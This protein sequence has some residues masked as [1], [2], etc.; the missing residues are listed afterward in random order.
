MTLPKFLTLGLLCAVIVSAVAFSWAPDL[1]VAELT[2]RWAPPPSTFVEVK[3]LKVHVRDEGPRN[4]PTP[5]VLLHGTSASLHT[6]DGWVAALKQNRRVIRMDLPG[7]GLTGPNA[8]NDYRS[9]AYARFVLDLMDVLGVQ[10]FVL[11]GNSLGGGIAWHTALLAPHRVERLILVDA[12]GYAFEPQSVP[13]GFRIAR[14]PG[15]N[16]L[17]EYLLPRRLVEA[18]VRNVYGEPSRVTPELVD[19]YQQLTLRE[20][21]RHALGLRLQ[22]EDFGGHAARIKAVK[23]PALI[24]WGGRDRLIPV[25]NATRFQQD[26]AG[27]ETIIFDDLGHV[28]QEEDPARTV[29]AVQEYLKH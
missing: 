10:R 14:I 17:T 25:A 1:P 21:N 4:D 2:A 29:K 13:I 5:I 18:S 22:Q 8:Q 28:P 9:E 27:S 11:A 20:G 26:I 23:V 16:R 3:G 6:W 24:L 12:A 7:F 15:L 19:R